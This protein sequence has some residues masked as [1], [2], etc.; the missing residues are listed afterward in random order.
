MLGDFPFNLLKP[1]QSKEGTVVGASKRR[2]EAYEIGK[3][4]LLL[5]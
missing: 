4:I 5:K 3:R 2:G 1:V